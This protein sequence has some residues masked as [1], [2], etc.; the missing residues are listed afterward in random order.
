MD[1]H[2]AIWK[3]G[4]REYDLSKKPL[5]MGIL[6]VTPDS[7]YDGGRHSGQKAAFEHACR[8]AEEGADL[9]DVG[10]ESSRPGSEP[11][12]YREER[13]RVIPVIK[14]LAGKLKI[15]V[16][17]DT[18]RAAVAM[19][20]IDEGALLV[21]DISAMRLDP[22]MAEIVSR[23]G[24]SVC[25]MHMQGTPGNMQDN[26]RYGDVVKE[27]IKFLKERISYCVSR[28]IERK[29]ILVDPGIGFGK[30]VKHN[31]R[32][33][34]NI[35]KFRATGRPVLVGLSRKSFIGKLLGVEAGERLYASVA[36]NA[37]CAAG[38]AGVLRVHDVKE[39]RQALDIIKYFVEGKN[40]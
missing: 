30:T 4:G 36:L 34:K 24:V 29:K 27:I 23:T 9:I 25:L 33:I 15:P 31:L 5:L 14:K 37:L 19:E 38:G 39:T 11:V 12:G 20:A 35:G 8:M 28:G 16:S 21:N 22:K 3:C 17:V 26:P 40:G 2:N 18:Y 13:A 32:I 1:K 7:F 10:G 6:N